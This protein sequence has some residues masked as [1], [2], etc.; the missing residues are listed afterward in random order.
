MPILAETKRKFFE[1]ETGKT[2]S[3]VDLEWEYYS[4][5]SGLTPKVL[6]SLADHKRVY[7]ETQTG[8]TK[9]PL[10][11]LEREFLNKQGIVAKPIGEAW[12]EYYDFDPLRLPNLELA[13]MADKFGGQLLA[14][15]TFTRPD[16]AL[17]NAETGQ[18]WAVTGGTWSI[19]NGEVTHTTLGATHWARIDVGTP[20]TDISAS[21][22]RPPVSSN[23]GIFARYTDS[24]NTIF[25]NIQDSGQVALYKVIGGTLTLLSSTST[26]YVASGASVT[27]RLVAQGSVAT[28]YVNGASV[29]TSSVSDVP[30]GNF[31]GL[32][33][34]ANTASP[35]LDNFEVRAITPVDGDPL[36]LWPDLSFPARLNDPARNLLPSEL[37]TATNG[38]AVASQGSTTIALET[39]SPIT[40]TSSFRCTAPASPVTDSGIQ[41]T[42]SPPYPAW[43]TPGR[44]YSASVRVKQPVGTQSLYLQIRFGRSDGSIAGVISGPLTV[45]GAAPVT[46]SVSGVAPA[47]ADRASIKVL[48]QNAPTAG[49]YFIVDEYAIYDGVAPSAWKEP[50]IG[51]HVTQATVAKKPLWRSQNKNLLT[52]NAATGTAGVSSDGWDSANGTAT[53]VSS[54][55]AVPIAG[56][57]SAKGTL[58]SGADLRM[59]ANSRSGASARIAKPNAIYYA[60]VTVKNTSTVARSVNVYVETFGDNGNTYLQS[61]RFGNSNVARTLN[62]GEVYTFTGQLISTT[63]ATTDRMQMLVTVPGATIGDSLVVDSAMISESPITTWL[64]PVTLPNNAPVVQFDGVDDLL[65]RASVTTGP[66]TVY[67]VALTNVAS[68]SIQTIVSETSTSSV[69]PR[70]SLLDFIGTAPRFSFR[71]DGNVESAATGA[72]AS[73]NVPYVL[74]GLR[75][76]SDVRLVVNGGTPVVTTGLTGTAVVTTLALGARFGITANSFLPGNISAVYVFSGAHDDATRK[77]VEK[78]LGARYG[79]AVAA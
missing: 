11:D 9:K 3:I 23:A 42:T 61:I 8:L 52:Y 17:G 77:R 78:Y 75:S 44:T 38:A 71:N 79:I 13:L 18:A 54:E 74:T 50:P 4:N 59:V 55:T 12:N 33:L 58:A 68:G 56:I 22:A 1:D 48:W 30:L 14:R 7:L 2:G 62:S 72:T 27:L 26:G 41:S 21:L 69:T 31:A 6:Y 24:S 65:E 29:L 66:H 64:P 36:T 63:A 47:G 40:G 60:T 57:S 49:D 32:R 51:R 67:A 34:F 16:G 45:V 73:I 35:K 20:D 28:V 37:A 15:D 19:V 76:A 5:R 10:V 25:A 43:V 39:T 46:L 53:T 70:A